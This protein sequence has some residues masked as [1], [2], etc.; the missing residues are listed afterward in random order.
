MND[1]LFTEMEV[2][3]SIGFFGKGMSCIFKDAESF[4]ERFISVRNQRDC[5]I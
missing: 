1:F 2:K 4:K 5:L 3:C